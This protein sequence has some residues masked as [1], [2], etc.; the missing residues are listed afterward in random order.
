MSPLDSTISIGLNPEPHVSSR[1][2]FAIFPEITP[3]VTKFTSS[4][5]FLVDSFESMISIFSLLSNEL[6]S[7]IMILD[8]S[9]ASLVFSIH[10]S[11]NVARFL[12]EEIICASFSGILNSD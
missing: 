8:K 1:T 6:I 11:K 7:P 12:D 3:S 9:F 10:S 2:V 4:E 5:T